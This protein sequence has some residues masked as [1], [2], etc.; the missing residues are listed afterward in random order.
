[1][2]ICCL[3]TLI[4]KKNFHWHSAKPHQQGIILPNSPHTYACCW[5]PHKL[6]LIN[7]Q[8]S[9][10]LA[11][12]CLFQTD[13]YNAPQIQRKKKRGKKK[14]FFVSFSQSKFSHFSNKKLTS[15]WNNTFLSAGIGWN[16]R[17]A[18]LFIRPYLTC[19]NSESSLQSCFV[20]RGHSAPNRW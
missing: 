17:S 3:C 4:N 13:T 18:S 16:F 8:V 15:C 6:F 20:L 10:F 11:L 9:F 5:N 19:R 14:D 1:M 2:Y 12:V 7:L